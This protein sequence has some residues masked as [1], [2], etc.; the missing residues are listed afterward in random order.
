M[1][2]INLN[3]PE[4]DLIFKSLKGNVRFVGGCVRDALLGI[5]AKD[6]DLAGTY[7]PEEATKL[8]ENN[9]IRVIPTG[10]EHGTITAIINK[11]PFE[12]TTLRSDIECY[13]RHAKVQFTDDWQEDA[14]RRDFTMNAMSCDA[15][16]KIYDYFNGQSDLKAGIVRFVGNAEERCKE[17]VLRI[18]RFFR[19]NAHYSG[20]QV[21]KDGLAACKK[22]AEQ[23]NE[24][25]GERIQAEMLKLLS[26][27]NPLQIMQAMQDAGISE[28]S[29]NTAVNLN[30]LGNLVAAEKDVKTQINPLLRLALII[31]NGKW[32]DVATRWKLSNK[33]KNYLKI[34][35]SN[36]SKLSKSSS[37]AEQRKLIR[38]LDKGLFKDIALI[39]WA[40]SP[41]DGEFYLKAINN[42]ANWQVPSFPVKGKD[43]LDI[44]IEPGPNMGATLKKAEN[45]WE[46][47]EYKADKQEIISYIKKG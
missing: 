27:P 43:L 36:Y 22:F 15:D 6:I 38:S 34:I 20:K 31:K 3:S 7:L 11:K 5:K 42:A 21:D 26:A 8:L 12:I 23:I 44:G 40:N 18:L 24:L 39:N 16:G 35:T 33:D 28:V 29:F 14:A 1:A 17:D 32:Q 10:I 19:F 2:V 9:G 45:W 41:Q 25:S 13:G 30:N 4:T 37:T 46:S 47:G